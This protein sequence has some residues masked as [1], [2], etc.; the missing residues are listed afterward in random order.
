MTAILETAFVNGLFLFNAIRLVS[1]VASATRID[2]NR[3]YYSSL[4]TV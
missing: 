4:L 3:E 2:L 1:F